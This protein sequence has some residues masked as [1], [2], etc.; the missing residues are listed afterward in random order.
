MVSNYIIVLPVLS[1]DDLIKKQGTPNQFVAA[2]VNGTGA[3]YPSQSVTFNINGVLYNRVTDGSGLAKLNI[4]LM[5]GEY[6]IT[7]SYNGT[8]I[9]NKVTVTS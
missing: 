3:P 1:A 5:P 9:A 4:N 7:S 8:N 6:I 2:L